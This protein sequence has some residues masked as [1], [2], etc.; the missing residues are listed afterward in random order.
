[1]ETRIMEAH[2]PLNDL[3]RVYAR[4]P[5]S[6]FS[7]SRQ[8]K[9]PDEQVRYSTIHSAFIFPV[10]GRARLSL[11][12]ESLIGEPG[13][14]LHGC[15]HKDL[16]FEALDDAPFEH[17]NIYYSAGENDDEDPEK[18]MDRPFDFHPGDFDELLIRVEALEALGSHP[19]LE[20]RLN[21]IIGATG[22]V[23]TMFDPTRRH[24]S[25][26]RVAYVRAY[27]EARYA[28]SLSLGDLAQ[29]CGL[30]EHRLSRC[31]Y[32]A[33]GMRPMSFLIARRLERAL[34][35]LQTDLLVKD[36]AAA[37]GYDDPLYFSRLFKK[38]YGCP[39]SAARSKRDL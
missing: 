37:V 22:L 23:K 11:G 4:R 21:Q 14:V 7:V 30:S 2:P 31:F 34:Q 15:P 8:V 33:Y 29:L 17:V 35:L 3:R 28:E 26:E 12:D 16:L 5:F 18:W 25:D 1:M 24:K 13:V 39:P 38:H 9:L 36:I 10:H 20:N 32:R 6:V 19:S 27:L